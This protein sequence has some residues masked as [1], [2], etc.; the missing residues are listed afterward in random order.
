MDAGSGSQNRASGS[1]PATAT[2]Q[3]EVKVYR[4]QVSDRSR[5]QQTVKNA[6]Y[7]TH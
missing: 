3:A 4:Y 2:I 1:N 5:V 6:Y 7:G